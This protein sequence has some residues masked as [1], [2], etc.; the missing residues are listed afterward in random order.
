MTNGEIFAGLIGVVSVLFALTYLNTVGFASRNH[1][2]QASANRWVLE[3]SAG[4]KGFALALLG[5]TAICLYALITRE[6]RGD[7]ERVV[8]VVF[9]VVQ[10]IATYAVLR[11]AFEVRC[12]FDG[13]GVEKHGPWGQGRLA[14]EEIDEVLYSGHVHAFELSAP[15]NKLRVSKYMSGLTAFLQCM[16]QHVRATALV[17]VRDDLYKLLR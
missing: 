13:D 8:F 6:Y 14:W 11:E 1:S 2:P 3:Y 4:F 7:A 9:V 17:H 10:L 12:I 5:L 15:G 16:E